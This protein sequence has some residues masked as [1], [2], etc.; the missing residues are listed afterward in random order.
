MLLVPVGPAMFETLNDAIDVLSVFTASGVEPI[1]FRWRGR[2]Y[3]IVKVSGRWHRR[4]GTGLLHHFSVECAGGDSFEL[5]YDPRPPRWTL[6]RA[7][8]GAA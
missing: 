8:V 6:T 7:W 1:R 5:C 3:R 2:V 4:E